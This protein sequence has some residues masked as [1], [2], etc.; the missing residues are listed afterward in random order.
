MSMTRIILADDHQL[1]RAGLRALLERMPEVEVVGEASDGLE[2]LSLIAGHQPDLALMDITMAGLNGLETTTR[3]VQEYP[4]TRVVI[5]SM[6]VNEEYVIQ[7]MRS[8]AVGYLLKDSATTELELAIRAVSNGETYLSPAVSKHLIEYVQ[9]LERQQTTVDPLTA[10]QREI[11]R[12]IA[13]GSTTQQIAGVLNL[14]I[15]TVEAH[16]AQIMERLDIHDLA[17]LVRYAIRSGLVS[18]S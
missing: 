7:A 10:R 8:G 15:K 16:R 17:G 3:I 2:A 12:L 11:L 1:V 4:A 5:L 9:R 14:S 18:A 6:H 13:E